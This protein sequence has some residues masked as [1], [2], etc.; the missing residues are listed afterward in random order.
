MTQ[1]KYSNG[2]VTVI[3]KPGLCQHSTRCWRGLVNVFDPRK[4]PWID[5]NGDTSE[6]IIEQVKKCPSR[7]LTYLENSN[8]NEEG[9]TLQ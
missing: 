9:H 4:K 2:E 3:W 8:D 7:A 1:K 5:M 6:R